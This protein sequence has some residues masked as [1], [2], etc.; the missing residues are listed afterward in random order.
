MDQ[1]TLALEAS[2]VRGTLID[3][4]K[5][6]RTPGANNVDAIARGLLAAGVESTDGD[7]PRVRLKR[8]AGA[9]S[10]AI[11]FEDLNSHNDE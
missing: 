1:N 9:S 5:G 10:A 7:R 6:K 4:E 3:F 2:V 11:P 8:V